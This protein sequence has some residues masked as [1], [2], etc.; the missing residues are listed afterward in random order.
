MSK[1]GLYE[2]TQKRNFD[3]TIALDSSFL[4][5]LEFLMTREDG[6]IEV[7]GA[8][9]GSPEPT[10][11]GGVF[12][13]CHGFVMGCFAVLLNV[14]YA[15]QVELL[16]VFY[17]ISYAWEK[18]LKSLMVRKKGTILSSTKAVGSFKMQFGGV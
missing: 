8:P 10:G 15:F 2:S 16:M 3:K 17:A 9:S 14:F 11:C 18:F 13:N 1:V 5:S 4:I 12:R 7:N 6:K